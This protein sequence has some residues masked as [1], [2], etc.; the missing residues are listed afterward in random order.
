LQW[1]VAAGVWSGAPCGVHGMGYPKYFYWFCTNLVSVLEESGEFGGGVSTPNHP[2]ASLLCVFNRYLINSDLLMLPSASEYLN[3]PRP[4]SAQRQVLR[5]RGCEN[6]ALRRLT[7]A[8]SGTSGVAIWCAR[9]A[10]HAGPSLW[11]RCGGRRALCGEEEGSFLILANYS[12][13]NLATPLSGKE[14]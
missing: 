10:V 2:V 4:T 14:C 11:G 6:V 7:S 3:Q 12:R 8:Q 13:S 9:R 1:G 5:D